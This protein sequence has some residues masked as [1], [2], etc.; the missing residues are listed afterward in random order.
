MRGDG[1][2]VMASPIATGEVAAQGGIEAI[3]R[4]LTLGAAARDAQLPLD[5][6]GQSIGTDP[7]GEGFYEVARQRQG[8]CRRADGRRG[9]RRD[10][11]RLRRD[12]RTAQ[13]VPALAPILHG[14]L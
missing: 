9:V 14:R 4:G 13:D 3:Q 10:V 6:P 5:E 12:P 11:P 7:L 2:G 1:W 8:R